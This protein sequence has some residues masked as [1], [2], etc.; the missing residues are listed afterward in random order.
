MEENKPN[1]ALESIWKLI[2]FCDEDIE[3]NKPW[4]LIKDNQDKAKEVLG[5]LLIALKE[6]A[7]LLSPFMPETSERIIK[8][9]KENKKTESLFPRF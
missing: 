3:K 6:I 7:D 1:E 4:E 8:Q 5:Q 9:I 2:S